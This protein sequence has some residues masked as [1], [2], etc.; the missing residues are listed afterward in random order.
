VDLRKF[1]ESM[2]TVDLGIVSRELELVERGLVLEEQGKTLRF[3]VRGAEHLECIAGV[4]NTRSKLYRLLGVDRDVDAYRRILEAVEKPAKAKETNFDMKEIEVDLLKLPFIKFFPRD[5]G[6]YATSCIYIACLE[7]SCNASIHRT[8]VVDRRSLVARI[9]PRHLHYIVEQNR[10]KGMETKIAIAIGAPPAAL[11]A[12][13]TSP[14]FG[15]FEMN[16]ATSIDPELRIAYTPRYGLPVPMP[17]AVVI[18]GRITME[19]VDEGPFV[20]ILAL[21]DRVRRQPLIKVDALY[22]DES[23]LFH[24]VIPSGSEHRLLQSFY[25]E[26]LVWQSVSKVVPRVHKVR[27][28]RGSGSWLH[29]VVSI[30]KAH[31][32]DGKNAILA[33]F[34]AHPSLKLVVVV[35]EDIDPDNIDEVEWAIATRFQGDRDLVVIPRARCSTLDPSSEDGLCT[36]IGIDATKPLHGGEMFERVRMGTR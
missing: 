35:D 12:A 20:D 1:A 6:L 11:L 2:D 14:P 26:A 36:K 16:V 18:E 33:T 32:G 23:Q 21:Y 8:M 7:N 24:V 17:S 3:R 4:L 34:A 19:L 10:S 13:A 5:G 15:V 29:A 30:T 27:F 9:V 31:E 22:V 25:R 28:T